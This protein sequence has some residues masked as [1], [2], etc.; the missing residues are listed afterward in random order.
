MDIFSLHKSVCQ[1]IPWPEGIP[2]Q[3]PVPSFIKVLRGPRLWEASS[4]SLSGSFTLRNNSISFI[5]FSRIFSWADLEMVTWIWCKVKSNSI[6][7]G[8]PTVLSIP[9]FIQSSQV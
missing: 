4:L 9:S 7:L 2:P 6:T 5:C 3:P 8:D 1:E